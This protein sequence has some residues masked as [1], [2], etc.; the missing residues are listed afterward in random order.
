MVDRT[1]TQRVKNQRDARLLEGWQEVR[2]WV[3]SEKDAVEIRNMASDRRAKAEALD[4][5]SKEVPKVSLHTEVRIAQAI[6][7]HGSAAYNT[8]SGAVLDLMTELAGEDDLQGFSRAVV[9]LARAKPANAKFVLARVPAKISN[10][11]IQYRGIAAF[12]LMKWTDANPQ[13]PDDLKGSVRNPEQFERVVEAM[14]ESIKA[15][16]KSH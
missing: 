3:P 4:G 2:V 16:A 6:A 14:V 5:L 7:E 8:P 10:F 11:V 15:F 9:I 13:W 12:D 1:V